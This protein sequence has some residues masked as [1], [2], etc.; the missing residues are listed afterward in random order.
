MCI[1]VYILYLYGYYYILLLYK[2]HIHIYNIIN[3]I[4]IY[5]NQFISLIIIY[6]T[7]ITFTHTHRILYSIFIIIYIYYIYT[8]IKFYIE[9]RIVFW[10]IFYTAQFQISKTI[11]WLTF[12]MA[13]DYYV[14]RRIKCLTVYNYFEFQFPWIVY[15]NG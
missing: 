13:Y 7:Y 9:T 2:Y 15:E 10:C 6:I 12:R 14:A 4:I 5:N 3:F 1:W 8:R 11:D